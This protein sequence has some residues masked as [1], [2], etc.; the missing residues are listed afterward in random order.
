MLDVPTKFLP[1]EDVDAF[2]VS[3]GMGFVPN[4]KI[5]SRPI[6]QPVDQPR[7]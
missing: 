7:A 3:F 1:P 6:V 2:T 4:P 5:W